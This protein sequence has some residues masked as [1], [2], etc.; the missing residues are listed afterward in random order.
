[1]VQATLMRGTIHMVAADDFWP[2]CAA[3]RSSRRE[4]WLRIAKGKRLP[5]ISHDALADVLRDALNVDRCRARRWSRQSSA[6][7]S[8]SPSGKVPAF[9]ST[10]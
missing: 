5:E 3:I 10:W 8:P 2:I 9:G 7:V 4:W 1:M 6:P